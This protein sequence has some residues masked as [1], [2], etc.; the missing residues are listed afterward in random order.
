MLPMGGAP[1]ANG[2]MPTMPGMP[3]MPPMGGGMPSMPTP[4][5][6]VAPQVQQLAQQQDQM[7][8]QQ[9]EMFRQQVVR[10]LTTL[11]TYNPAGQQA[12]SQPLPPNVGEYGEAPQEEANEAEMES[13]YS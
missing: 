2:P 1:A 10:L 7:Q 5:G 3:S 9:M 12:V 11:P 13:E 4:A 6:M 8:Q